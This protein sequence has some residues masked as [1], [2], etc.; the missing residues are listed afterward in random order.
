[1]RRSLLL[2][3]P[4]LLV[5]CTPE[6][7][8]PPP[9]PT[10]IQT[11][12]GML[13]SAPFDLMRRGSHVLR[14]DDNDLYFVESQTVNLR[15]FENKSVEIKGLMEANT[16]PSLLPVLLAT[17]VKLLTEDTRS[18]TLTSLNLSCRIPSDWEKTGSDIVTQF[19]PTGMA[20]PLVT[21]RKEAGTTLPPG[22]PFLLA[23]RHGVR[24]VNTVTQAQTVTI[25]DGTSLLTFSFFPDPASLTDLLRAQ[26]SS[27]LDSVQ[28]TSSSSSLSAASSS[29]VVEGTPCG[30]EAGILCP[31]GSYCAI[32]DFKLN[33]GRCK[34]AK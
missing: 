4:L 11:V 9:L 7:S 26:W 10:G 16:E 17:D 34:Q 18:V 24:T 6:P 27:F 23:G 12:S 21:I 25:L 29:S 14:K 2:I 13:V 5:A 19:I 30:G 8:P 1:M 22:S 33:V 15:A 28:F 3:L 32:S 20:A 31:A